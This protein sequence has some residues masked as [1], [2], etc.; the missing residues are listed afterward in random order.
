[1]YQYNIPS[2]AVIGED[3]KLITNLSA[4]DLRGMSGIFKNYIK[5]FYLIKFN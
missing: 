2:V 4:S 1:M 5:F 3:Y